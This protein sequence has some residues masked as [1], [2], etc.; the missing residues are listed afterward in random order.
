MSYRASA[1]GARTPDILK[2]LR[3][4]PRLSMPPSS[5]R[6]SA[7]PR[8]PAAGSR[9]PSRSGAGTPGGERDGSGVPV[10]EYVPGNPRDPLDMEIANVVNSLGHALVVKRVDP[11]LRGTP[12]E[13][14]EVRAQYTFT[15]P[16]TTKAVTCKL[17][18]LS[19]PGTSGKTKRVMCRVGGGWQD[20]RTYV[21]SRQTRNVG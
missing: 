14:E 11:P 13:N 2:A 8:T 4:T 6:E 9:P 18:T 1:D 19:R 5:F 20:L 3:A 17:T 16:L 10:H 15:G 21:L 12:K 7:S